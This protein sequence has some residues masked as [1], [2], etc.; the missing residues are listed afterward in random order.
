MDKIESLVKDSCKIYENDGVQYSPSIYNVV[1]SPIRVKSL[2]VTSLNS[3]VSYINRN[4]DKIEAEN[5]MVQIVDENYVMLVSKVKKPWNIRDIYCI[6]VQP[7][8]DPFPCGQW[9][10]PEE[11]IIKLKV[12]FKQTGGQEHLLEYTSKLD[13]S[14]VSKLSDDG[15]S[16]TASVRTGISGA[17]TEA[18]GVPAYVD[19]QPH[20]IFAELEQP[21]STFL[22]RL[23]QANGIKA[24]LYEA[25]GGLWKIEAMKRIYDYL[26]KF[27]V[28]KKIIII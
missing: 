23:K 14:S 16:Q 22:F 10:E 26:H 13:I 1:N 11:F 2:E 6:A 24:S 18:Q 4:I 7:K 8:M 20:R 17:L 3:L 19:L 27:I 9:M 28:D 25:D 12:Q 21:Q 15:V 5:M